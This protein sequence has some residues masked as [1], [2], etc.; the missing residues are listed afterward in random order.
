MIYA[1][2]D[3]QGIC[4][5]GNTQFGDSIDDE[6]FIVYILYEI[7]KSYGSKLGICVHDSD[8][9][10]LLIEAADHLPIWLGPED[11]DNRVWIKD[12]K[13][14]LIPLDEPGRKR[15]GGIGIRDALVALQNA[16]RTQA[17][18]VVQSCL[19][20]RITCFPQYAFATMHKAVC[21]LPRHLAILITMDPQLIAA[22]VSAFCT[23]QGAN[24]EK[25]DIKYISAMSKFGSYCHDFSDYVTIPVTFSRAHY[26]RLSFQKFH[27]PKKFH[28]AMMK[29]NCSSLDSSSSLSSSTSSDRNLK[30]QKAFDLGVRVTCGFE[31]CYQ[32]SSEKELSKTEHVWNTYIKNL[33]NVGYFEKYSEDTTEY[34]IKIKQAKE[35]VKKTLA[36]QIPKEEESGDD[37]A[38]VL[39]SVEVGHPFHLVVDCMAAD[40]RYGRVLIDSSPDH[41]SDN[42]YWLYMSPQDFEME[43]NRRVAREN[44][45]DVTTANR[46]SE[47]GDVAGSDNGNNSKK[48]KDSAP[49]NYKSSSDHMQEMEN[50]VSSM[51]SFMSFGSDYEGIEP[52]NMTA[53]TKTTPK[54]DTNSTKSNEANEEVRSGTDGEVTLNDF[55]VDKFL[56]ILQNEMNIINGNKDKDRG[57]NNEDTSIEDDT[58]YFSEG[59]YDYVDDDDDDDDSVR[60][61]EIDDFYAGGNSTSAPRSPSTAGVGSF[62]LS[63]AENGSNYVVE[64]EFDSDD[65]Q[66]GEEDDDHP[67]FMDDYL[68][69]M[70]EELGNTSLME[71]F[72]KKVQDPD[73]PIDGTSGVDLDLTV[74][75]NLLESHSLQVGGTGPASALLAQMGLK[76]P[77]GEVQEE[78][79]DGTE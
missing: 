56:S 73:L 34:T 62:V 41:T 2:D 27:P 22:A 46:K 5:Q 72:E 11:S 67:E 28:N 19:M 31:L 17:E 47:I 79:G 42:D 25:K 38:I 45:D 68:A 40:V 10:F 53:E 49:G 29:M 59:D 4:L 71:T 3:H 32:N 50:I 70:E 77:T 37:D 76:F 44:G 74:I 9:Q 23:S 61:K 26:A 35:Y 39:R 66:E 75:K 7:S 36:R 54:N 12:G 15:D 69:A 18:E 16:N 33:S 24:R 6:W 65:E 57:A 78:G 30:A 13:L 48:E 43:M 51:K 58:D 52:V 14:H 8:G 63:G 20:K 21:T 60:S 64:D 55:N 1:Q